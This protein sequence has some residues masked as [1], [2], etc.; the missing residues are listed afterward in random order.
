MTQRTEPGVDE[1]TIIARRP[2][3]PTRAGS[4]RRGA[5]GVPANE[6]RPPEPVTLLPSA[7]NT[8][9]RPLPSRPTTGTSLTVPVP[10]QPRHEE[11]ILSAAAT[12]LLVVVAHLRGTVQQA[13]VAAL[14]KEIVDQ[15]RRFETRAVGFGATG[16]DVSAARYALCSLIDETVMTTPWG[17]ASD[18]SVRS[19]LLEFHSE[20]WGGEKVFS[21]LDR[22]RADAQKHLALLKLI[23]FCL[24]L[25][26]EGKYR[27]LDNGREQLGDLRLDIARL[28][29]KFGKA[30]PRELSP[31]WRG[32]EQKRKLRQFVPL[33][34]VFAL[35]LVVIL[36]AYA[37]V[38][39]RVSGETD[40]ALHALDAVGRS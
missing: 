1:P 24:L 38:K 18:W 7:D 37:V 10:E 29:R 25:G 12:P 9:P 20:T 6:W 35:A 5:G 22:V 3:G 36:A 39:V 32:T 23:D 14:R 28:L 16:T 40:P 33:W 13:D 26:F 8:G 21:I 31:S 17:S 19:L 27:V 30:P 15:M 2:V 34:A 11:D 4:P